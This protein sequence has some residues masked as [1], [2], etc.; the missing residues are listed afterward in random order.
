MNILAVGQSNMR[1]GA[2]AQDGPRLNTIDARVLV[3]NNTQDNG[4]DGTAF[5]SPPIQ[6][7]VP[8]G[9]GSLSGA[10]NLAGWFCHRAAQELQEGIKLVLVAKGGSAVSLWDPD[11]GVNYQHV[12]SAYTASGNRPPT[13][14]FGIR[15]RATIPTPRRI[16]RP[17]LRT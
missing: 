1:G 6:G 11:T 14:C 16:T 3:W 8:W 15:A 12:D 5:I 13:S 2:G 4:P 10:N 9:T 17:S 7:N